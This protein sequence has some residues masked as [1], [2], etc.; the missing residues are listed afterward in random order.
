MKSLKSSRERS[1]LSQRKL[2]AL[3]RISYKTVQLLESGRHDPKISTLKNIARALG[4]PPRTVN[5]RIESLWKSPN[6]SVEM[7]SERIL[8]EGDASWKIW[9]F[10]FVDAFRSTQDRSLINRPPAPETPARIK[11][12]LASTVETLCAKF[13]IPTPDWCRSVP[14]LEEPWFVAEIENLKPLALVE[15][16]VHFRKRNIFVLNNFL[17]RV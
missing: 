5:H 11:A 3:A 6:D 2:A 10:N 15:S 1:G 7:V 13:Q 4:Y 8:T 16:P 9:L 17:E 14:R 12:L